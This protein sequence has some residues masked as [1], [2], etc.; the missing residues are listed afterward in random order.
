MIAESFKGVQAASWQTRSCTPWL[1]WLSELRDP[2]S[3]NI[4][5]A[6]HLWQLGT[7]LLRWAPPSSKGPEAWPRIRLSG[8]C[9]SGKVWL[10]LG[11]GSLGGSTLSSC[12][13][14]CN[15]LSGLTIEPSLSL[16]PGP[17]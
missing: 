6:R 4:V 7:I 13:A 5:P 3:F 11:R 15:L 16:G 17:E 14:S 2:A 10:G 8:S 12:K 9:G 1:R